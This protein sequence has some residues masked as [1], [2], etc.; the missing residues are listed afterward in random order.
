[1]KIT[2]VK[3]FV[4]D[5]FGR[6]SAAWPWTFVQVET[7][8]GVTGVGEAS[9]SPGNGSLM[10]ADALRRLKEFVVGEDP[11]DITRL[12]HKLFRK[13]AYLGPRGLPTAVI[14][15]IDIAL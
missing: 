7:D 5:P 9:N 1:M 15:G 12:W 4:V 2:N 6:G 3:V 14:S 13:A 11:A 10:V 8:E